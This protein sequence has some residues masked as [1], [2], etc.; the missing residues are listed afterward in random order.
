M[1]SNPISVRT[2][3]EVE[4]VLSFPQLFPCCSVFIWPVC[5][6]VLQPSH[7]WLLPLVHSGSLVG[8]KTL[9]F[10]LLGFPPWYDIKS[11]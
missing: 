3:T 8:E 7:S 10:T 6:E 2:E 1:Q 4:R 5:R 11:T 9:S